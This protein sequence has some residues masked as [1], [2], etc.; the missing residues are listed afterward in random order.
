MD[1]RDDKAEQWKEL[2]EKIR[3][4]KFAMLTTENEG[5]FLHSRPMAT[6][7]ASESGAFWFFTGKSSLKVREID[8]DG[9]VNLS[10][11]SGDRDTYVSV[12]GEARVVQDAAKAKALWNPFMKAWFP[13]GLDDPDLILLRVD[14]D[15]AEYWDVTSKKMTT[16][17]RFAKNLV[18][19]GDREEPPGHGKIRPDG[20]FEIDSRR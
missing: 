1:N 4:I 20:D 11:I 6:L 7:E 19:A 12:A 15:E 5:G 13:Q 10:Y 3:D 17:I 18:G 16:L 8:H 14:V 2:L 9:R